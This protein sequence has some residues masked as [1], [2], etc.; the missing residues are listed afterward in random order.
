MGPLRVAA[1]PLAVLL[2]AA[3]PLNPEAARAV[4]KLEIIEAHKAKPGSRMIFTRSELIAWGNARVLD[5]VPHG[6]RDFTMELAEGT[7]TGHAFI[8]FAR[9]RHTDES[10][11]SLIE[12]LI[13]GERPV[14]IKVAI[15]SANGICTVTVQRLEISG[16]A[17]PSYVLDTIVKSFVRPMFPDIKI[18]EPFELPHNID[19][20]RPTP[21]ALVINFK[22]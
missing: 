10:D 12:K 14:T 15:A 18:G 2:C 8:D 19:R 5:Y 17:A 16:I 7:A 20:I 6:F 21:N 3:G 11:L 22:K 1:F 13:A 9:V 4:H